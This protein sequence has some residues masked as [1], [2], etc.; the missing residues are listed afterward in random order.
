MQ[1]SASAATDGAPDRVG[2][3]LHELAEAARARLLVAEH[4]A[5]AIAAVGL[6]Q[7][8][9]SSRRRSGR[10][11]RSGRSAATATARRRPGTRTRP[12]SAGPGRAGTCP[13]RRCIRRSGVSTR[14]EA[15]EL[16]DLADRREHPLGGG[17]IGGSRGRRSRAAARALI[18]SALDMVLQQPLDWENVLR[19]YALRRGGARVV[20]ISRAIR[21]RAEGEGRG[22]GW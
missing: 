21:R 2:V 7:A 17:D 3:E 13:A 12:R 10:A 16:V 18:L 8:R 20:E 11:A 14:L 6:G 1:I 5:G 19:S 9:R 15:V 22:S 4:P